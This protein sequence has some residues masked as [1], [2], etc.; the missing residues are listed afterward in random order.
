MRLFPCQLFLLTTM[1]TFLV[2]SQYFIPTY[3]KILI[4]YNSNFGEIIFWDTIDIVYTLVFYFVPCSSFF[5]LGSLHSN[6]SGMG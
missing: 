2:F 6:A 3:G 5:Q 4:I 1:E